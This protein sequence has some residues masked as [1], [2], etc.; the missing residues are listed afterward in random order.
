MTAFLTNKGAE[1]GVIL[2]WVKVTG[3]NAFVVSTTLPRSGTKSFKF[4]PGGSGGGVGIALEHTITDTDLVAAMAG[5]VVN[6]VVWVAIVNLLFGGGDSG[7]RYRF[8]VKDDVGNGDWVNMFSGASPTGEVDS[9]YRQFVATR[10]I[11]ANATTVSLGLDYFKAG[12]RSAYEFH[13]DDLEMQAGGVGGVNTYPIDAF[14]RVTSL[15]YRYNRGVFTTELGLG[16]VISDFDIPVVD[17]APPKS[18]VS[19][20]HHRVLIEQFTDPE[21]LVPEGGGGVQE[22]Q[23]LIAEVEAGTERDSR[24]IPRQEGTGIRTTQEHHRRLVEQFSDPERL[25]PKGGGGVQEIQDLVASILSGAGIVRPGV[26]Q[27]SSRAE[28]GTTGLARERQRMRELRAQ[29]L[30]REQIN[31]IIAAES[32]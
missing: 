20:E 4:S 9:T 8:R 28:L 17:D 30:S 22:V 14:T 27:P 25:I 11:D 3:S 7:S 13:I 12:T 23:K 32:R 5:Q 24:V 18:Y 31:R 19:A 29:G 1:D 6:F 26:T 10:T 21:R 16:G 2:P 15:T